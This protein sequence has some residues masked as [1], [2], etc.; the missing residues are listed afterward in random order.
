MLRGLLRLMLPCSLFVAACAASAQPV[1][2]L[3]AEYWEWRAANQPATSDD[4]PRIVR[5][6]GWV[7]DWSPEAVRQRQ[8]DLAAFED[9]WRALAEAPQSVTERVDYRLVGSALARA[10]WELEVVAAWRR[11]PQFYVDQALIPIFELLLPPPPV[12]RARAEGVIR[13]LESIPAMLTAGQRNLDD[14]R[15]PFVDV[16]L[17]G[18]DRVA[19]SLQGMATGL[20]PFMTPTQERRTRGALERAVAA[21][22]AYR[23]FLQQRR[24]GLPSETAVGRQGY[25]YFLSQVALLPYAPEQLLIM[26]RQEW[27]RT[28]Q[29]EALERNRN[30]G[31]PE[32]AIG[33]DIGAVVSRLDADELRVREFLE[34]H[35]ILTIP[36]WAGHYN[37]MAFP[38]YLA[39]IGWLGRTFDLTGL[40]RV[41]Q[42]ATV[43][44]PEPSPALG[45]FNLS[46]A[47]DPRPIIVHEGV[48]GH[49]LQLTLSWRHPNPLRRRY[50]DSAANEGTGFYAEEM[51]LQAGLFDD[52]PRTR[53]IIYSFARLRAL[54]VEVDVKLALG[55]FTIAEAAE[56]LETAV[57]MDRAT[58]EEEAVFFAASPGQAISY[59]IGKIQTLDFLAEARTRLGERFDLRHFH[60]Y[61]WQN[62]NV[63]IA[64]QKEEYLSMAAGAGQ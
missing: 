39:P 27:A 4:I 15:G 8:A 5:P 24:D 28:V 18:L 13:L 56:Y 25:E 44:L 38:A 63:P 49:F 60:D 61:L 45:F 53:E 22:E 34:T 26:G 7:P 6:D 54:R 20:E 46:I 62:G 29:F 35:D 48:P 64:L 37:A 58:A 33:P 40:D 9:R 50:Y 19:P 11:Q 14:M 1:Q 52:S 31:A 59:Q 42:N 16:A 17:G 30:R 23:A 36:D 57:P 47:R 41:G 43:Y 55:E 3:S 2:A 21:F 51:M 12:E 32:L 10:R